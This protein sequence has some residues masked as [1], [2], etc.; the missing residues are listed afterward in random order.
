MSWILPL[1][2]WLVALATCLYAAPVLWWWES[3]RRQF[4]SLCETNRVELDQLE[5][6][7]LAIGVERILDSHLADFRLM[8]VVNDKFCRLTR[9]SI[10]QLGFSRDFWSLL[11]TFV[12]REQS[13]CRALRILAS[14]AT[15]ERAY[16]R[17][18]KP[19]LDDV[20]L[21]HSAALERGNHLGALWIHLCGIVTFWRTVVV[22]AAAAAATEA[23][24]RLLGS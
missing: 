11:L 2:T 18:F 1:L 24:R 6:R 7:I 23:K 10:L 9:L 8:Q 5:S 12:L 3:R 14:R 4:R 19:Q 20:E 21:E 17:I 13:P 16:A 22:Y 15:C